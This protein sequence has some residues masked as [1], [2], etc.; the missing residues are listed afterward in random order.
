MTILQRDIN[1]GRQSLELVEVST[2]DWVD[3]GEAE[4]S[5]APRLRVRIVSDS[6]DFQSYAICEIWGGIGWSEISNIHYSQMKTKTKLYYEVK[7]VDAIIHFRCFE[8][9]RDRLI[10]LALEILS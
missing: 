1:R 2:L 3:T 9:D 4:N 10:D 7:E 6:Y 5:V 8:A